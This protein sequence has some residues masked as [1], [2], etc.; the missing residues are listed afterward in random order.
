MM[1]I[2]TTGVFATNKTELKIKKNNTKTI[3]IKKK[4]KIFSQ[5][6]CYTKTPISG[7]CSNSKEILIGYFTV[8]FNCE[9]GAVVNSDFYQTGNRCSSTEELEELQ[10]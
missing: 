5:D 9:T 1:A 4:S 2:V 7:T 6:N 10:P 3:A 8:F